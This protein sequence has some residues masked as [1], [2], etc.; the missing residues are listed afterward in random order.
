[1]KVTYNW[2]RDF[3]EIKISPQALAEK[4]TMAG[5]EVTSLEKKDGDYVFDIEVTPNRSD[6]LSVIGIAREVAAVTNKKLK[7]PGASTSPRYHATSHHR[8]GKL[9]IKIEDK[10]DCSL[11]TAKIIRGVKVRVS[12]EWL[13]KRLELVGCRSVNN[14][15]DI[16]N[17]ILFEWGEPLHAF[18]LDKLNAQQI[19]VRRGRNQEKIITIDGKER[20]LS[21]NILVIADKEKPVAVAGVM[22]GRDSEVLEST[23]NILLE[24]AV[25]NPIIVRRSRQALGLE[26]E[27]SYRFER[28]LD[29]ETALHAS[30]AASELIKKLAGG[31][32]DSVYRAGSNRIRKKIVTLNPSYFNKIL[33]INITLTKIKALLKNLGFQ[34][35]AYS[36]KNI[37]IEIPA[38]RSDV[39]MAVDLVEEIARIHGYRAIPQTQPLLRPRVKPCAERVKSARVKNILLGLGSSEVITYSLI[40]REILHNFCV[41]EAVAIQNPLNRGQEILRPTLLASLIK[42]LAYNLHQKQEYINI[43]ETAKIFYRSENKPKEELVLGLALCGTRPLLLEQGMVKDS[44]SMLHLKGI[45][46]TLF[47]RLG[48][49]NYEFIDCED[50]H[51]VN[52]LCHKRQVGLILEANR[53]ILEK[54]GIK[55]KRVFLA[56]INLNALAPFFSAEKIF[57]P[58]PL[59]PGITYDISVVIKEETGVKKILQAVKEIGGQLLEE[60]KII[61]YYRGKQIPRGFKGITLSCLYRCRERTLRQEETACLHSSVCKLLTETFGAEIRG[62]VK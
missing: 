31:Y 22:G 56:E 62:N 47:Q 6:C 2:L 19:A 51:K 25:F 26:S 29:F 34:I 3:V 58:P 16:T 59:Y 50:P 17:Y 42:C 10:K 54:A 4:L 30:W 39:T 37:R 12:P 24:A 53:E 43:F 44:V 14:I 18:D 49:S 13:R 48:I 40:N 20:V 46:E 15:V 35:K 38:F 27:S 7:L 23:N 11:Y 5:L 41:N 9:K 8:T 36:K 33:G 61:D 60:V 55:N 1:M 57:Q 52:V 21:A 45:L 32:V 28:G